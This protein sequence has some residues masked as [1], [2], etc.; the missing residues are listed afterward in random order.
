MILH[1]QVSYVSKSFNIVNEYER[2]AMSCIAMGEEYYVM[3]IRSK[4]LLKRSQVNFWT[5]DS[6]SLTSYFF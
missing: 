3:D 2:T 6:S 5:G 4:K 1:M